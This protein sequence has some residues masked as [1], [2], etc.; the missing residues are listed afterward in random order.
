MAKCVNCGGGSLALSVSGETKK[1][2]DC[3]CANLVVGDKHI[4]AAAK[5]KRVL[6]NGHFAIA[7]KESSQ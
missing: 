2:R 5:F 6:D 3:G 7:Q 1:C 4:T